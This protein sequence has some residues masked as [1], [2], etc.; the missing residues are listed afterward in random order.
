MHG[1]HGRCVL[2]GCGGKENIGE[3]F[4]MSFSSAV[5]TIATAAGSSSTEGSTRVF[6]EETKQH[7]LVVNN[8]TREEGVH[9]QKG[10]G[11]RGGRDEIFQ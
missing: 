9:K 6:P 10:R 5:L 11:E 7:C 8:S 2:T 3:D 4:G 1:I